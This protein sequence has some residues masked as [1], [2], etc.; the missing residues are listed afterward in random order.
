MEEAGQNR[1]I[2]IGGRL[3]HARLN[4]RLS[5]RQLAEKV[6][7][8]ESFLSKVE[9]NKVRP[10]LPMIHKIAVNLG[11]SVASLFSEEPDSAGAVTVMTA[12]KRQILRTE[13]SRAGSGVALETLVPNHLCTLLEA[14]IHHI[15]V[16]TSSQGFLE[17]QGEEMGYVLEGE[18]ELNVD[19]QLTIVKAGDS[20]FFLSHLAHGY[21]NI[22]TV[23]ARVLW[24]NTPQSF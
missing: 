3:K 24:V 18:L 7:C 13:H 1:E 10:S 15:P 19:G 17:H 23:E 4:R 21:K 8:T 20:F 5:L 14:N 11:I 2:I 12:G 6:G 9:N 22:G 16:G